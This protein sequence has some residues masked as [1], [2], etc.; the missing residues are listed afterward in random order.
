MSEKLEMSKSFK[1]SILKKVPEVYS[2]VKV[3]HVHLGPDGYKIALTALLG[4]TPSNWEVDEIYQ[5]RSG[6]ILEELQ[7]I[8]SDKLKYFYV[9]QYICE[10]FSAFDK[11]C[12]WFKYFHLDLAIY[13][14]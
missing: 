13:I 5:N 4:Y 9:E 1:M 3:D 11:E 12:K 7:E 10:M 14:N 8:I 6:L 2:A